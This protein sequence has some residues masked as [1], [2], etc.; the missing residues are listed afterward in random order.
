MLHDNY[1][2]LVKSN[3]QQF[4]KVGS[5]IQPE[6]LEIKATAQRVWIRPTYT[7]SPSL[8]RDRKIKMK[9]SIDQKVN[10]VAK[11]VELVVP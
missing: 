8:S 10:D 7:A 3:K 1:L 6:N 2:C 5:K 4:Q 9:K 11:G